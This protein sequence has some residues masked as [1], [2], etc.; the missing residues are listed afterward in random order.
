MNMNAEPLTRS[1]LNQ[2]LKRAISKFKGLRVVLE[3]IL[4][5]GEGAWD[6]DPRYPTDT[7]S[8]TVWLQLLISEAYGEGLKIEDKIRIMDRVRYYG[9]H[10]AYGLR[11][12]YV[13]HWLAIDPK[14]FDLIDLSSF[15][16]FRRRVIELDYE[17]F[18]SFHGYSCSLYREDLRKI[19][20][21]YLTSEGFRNYVETLEPG[22]YI[23]FPMAGDKYLEMYGKNS[24]PMGMV[25]S[26]I[27]E[28]NPM[29]EQAVNPYPKS[30]SAA[31]YHA[32]TFRGS[33]VKMELPEY[34]NKMQTIFDGYTVFELDYTWD[35]RA[36]AIED[37]A[38]ENIKRCE[39]SLP[40]N[41][42]NRKL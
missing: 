16:G 7:V 18:K 34:I 32:S 36:P 27:L 12:H 4:G 5:E 25:H 38:V 30:A 14:P 3:D 37:E 2:R 9:G 21:E 29:A 23:S 24:G 15:D 35:F 1:A 42:L 39:A 28:V 19:E 40:R 8:C 10:V 13:D 22:Y 6:S 11:K 17:R 20:V 26:V 33:V 41:P 31:I